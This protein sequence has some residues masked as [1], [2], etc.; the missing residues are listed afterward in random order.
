MIKYLLLLLPLSIF[1]GPGDDVMKFFEEETVESMFEKNEV[2]RK[3][4]ED[5][6]IDWINSRYKRLYK[7]V[8]V[9]NSKIKFVLREDKIV[10]T[11]DQLYSELSH[12]RS[13]NYKICL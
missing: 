11:K 8:V 2:V 7:A 6:K 4:P 3:T 12:L 13:K 9:N 5:F 1:A 10:L